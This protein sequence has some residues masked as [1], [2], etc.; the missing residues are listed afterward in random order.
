MTASRLLFRARARVDQEA[1]RRW[2]GEALGHREILRCI[3]DRDWDLLARA[4]PLAE[5]FSSRRPTERT[6]LFRMR[7]DS[8][9]RGKSPHPLARDSL[10]A[11]LA[12]TRFFS[13]VSSRRQQQDE[14]KYHPCYLPAR[15]MAFPWLAGYF[16]LQIVTSMTD[17]RNSIAIA[18][19]F[20]S[21]SID[22][23]S[24]SEAILTLPLNR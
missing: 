2:R 12:F 20:V 5:C 23:L 18:C 16:D 4:F 13:L 14:A 24:L 7:N 21:R 6:F 19:D 3:R 17:R 10:S 1:C 22:A 8:V 9:P 15:L 11:F